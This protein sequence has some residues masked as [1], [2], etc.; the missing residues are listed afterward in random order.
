V[1]TTN[2]K[3]DIT[4]TPEW[5]NMTWQQKRE[6]R[7][8]VW[9]NPED[10]NFVSPEAEKAYKARVGR[11]VKALKL[12]EPDRVP[13]MLPSGNFPAYYAGIDFRTLMYDYDAMKKAWI[14]FMD[15]FGD[16]DTLM[17]PGLVPCGTIAEIMQSRITALPGLGLPE[18]ASMN[19]IIEG[20]YMLADEYD[21]YIKD[22]TDFQLRTMLPR[23]T[24][25]FDSF[26]KLPPLRMIRGEMWVS[27][28]ADPDV[29]KTF[30]TLMNMADVE[31]KHRDAH[32]EMNRIILSRGYPSFLG[33]G[34]MVGAPF[35]HFADLLRG[36]RGISLDL[37]R[38]PEKVKEGMAMQLAFG[39]ERIEGFP[40]TPCPICAIPLHKGDD[41]F[42]SDRQFEEFYWP[43]L[44]AVMMAMVEEGLV[45][46]P[47]AEGKYTRRLKQIN[48]TPK[49]AV[50]WWFDQTDMAAAKKTI[51]DICCIMGN[52]PTSVVMTHTREQV[53][54]ACRQVIEDCKDGGGYIL[55]GGAAIDHGKFENLK[56]MMEAATEYGTY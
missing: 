34:L 4:T 55:S 42:M 48:D 35:D 10:A 30:E 51:G 18:N 11:F 25:L 9:Q 7:F 14:K 54:E 43:G 2:L 6:E 5:Q 50:A 15:D 38:Q 20:E 21:D 13:V 29:R 46:M 8:K 33:F 1:T 31:R 44:R 56:A 28:L 40:M 49:G 19:Q 22:P 26:R 41:V 3:P 37:Y 23:T 52:V 32:E 16:M 47:F 17:G 45:P 24:G 12:E 39:L 53:K 36:T 27:I